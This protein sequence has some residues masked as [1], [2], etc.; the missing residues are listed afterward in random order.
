[1]Q[2]IAWILAGLFA[3]LSLVLAVRGRK[4]GSRSQAHLDPREAGGSAGLDRG[5]PDPE[6]ALRGMSRYLTAAVLQPLER[7]LDDG[8]LRGCVEDAVDALEDLAFHARAAPEADATRQNLIALIQDVTREYTRDSGIPVKCTGPGRPI[9]SR[10]SA[11]QFKDA[12]YLLLANAGRFGG[13]RT[14]DV[15]VEE[16]GRRVRI[17]IRDRG[18]GFRD[19]ALRRA[20]EP[21]WTT[22]PDALGMGLTYARRLL[23][24][25]DGEIRVGN[26]DG[27]GGE[28]VASLSIEP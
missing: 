12:F 10:L 1:M 11:E 14:I 3:A 21:F 2:T 6:P 7:G 25:H 16:E 18:S 19:E 17:A 5:D 28:V 15:V 13:G 27:G 20:F 4:I 24:A 23:E 9:H 8:D 26:R 22:E